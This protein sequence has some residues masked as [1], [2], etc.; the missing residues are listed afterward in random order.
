MTFSGVSRG[1][2]SLNL[3]LT[4]Y[5]THV[6]L[7]VLGIEVTACVTILDRVIRPPPPV[8]RFHTGRGERQIRHKGK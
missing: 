2:F 1:H 7:A 6:H 5:A 3:Q 4:L 8:G